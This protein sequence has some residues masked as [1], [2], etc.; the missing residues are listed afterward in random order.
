MLPILGCSGPQSFDAHRGDI[1]IFIIPYTEA[2]D[3]TVKAGW[4]VYFLEFTVIIEGFR[5]FDVTTN[6]R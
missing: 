4:E 3:V 6:P 2:P 5:F 1:C